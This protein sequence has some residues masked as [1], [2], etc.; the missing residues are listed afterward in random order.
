[1]HLRTLF[2]N[3]N[4]KYELGPH[5]EIVVPAGYQIKPAF[6]LTLVEFNN[7]STGITK[8]GNK[9]YLTFMKI[10][11]IFGK[12]ILCKRLPHVNKKYKKPN[13][14]VALQRR[15]QDINRKVG[16]FFM[17]NNPHIRII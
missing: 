5:C 6:N 14:F 1:M 4:F 15:S 7:V 3:I 11:K 9:N 13:T 2:V 12:I 8:R 10:S 17:P 16:V